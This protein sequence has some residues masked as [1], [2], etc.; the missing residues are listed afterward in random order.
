MIMA[1]RIVIIII[2]VICAIGSI[3]ERENKELQRSCTAIVI[4]GMG[5]FLATYFIE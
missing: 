1:F 3:G 2:V 4:S 5:A